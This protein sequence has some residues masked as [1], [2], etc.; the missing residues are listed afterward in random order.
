MWVSLQ[1]ML[2]YKELCSICRLLFYNEV[3][4]ICRSLCRLLV[5]VGRLLWVMSNNTCNEVCSIRGPLCRLC[6]VVMRQGPTQAYS[7]LV[8]QGL[9][10]PQDV[11][12]ERGVSL[13]QA[14][15][16]R[17]ALLHLPPV[18]QRQV[19]YHGYQHRKHPETIRRHYPSERTVIL[20]YYYST[21]TIKLFRIL[22]HSYQQS[23]VWI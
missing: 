2:C 9:L 7:R 11:L 15:E 20:Q 22:N 8:L 5:V 19:G 21:I 6:Y 23:L 14:A 17:L 18:N 1:V 10:Q 12:L 16:L 3:C 13:L 4:S